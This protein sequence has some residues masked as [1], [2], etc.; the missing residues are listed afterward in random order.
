LGRATY[1]IPTD[2]LDQLS[3]LEARTDEIVPKVLQAG[4]E[5]V[6]ESV[7][8]HLQAVVGVGTKYPARTTG[9]LINA[10]GVSGA[11]LD[12]RG[13][14]TVKVGF[15]EP[16]RSG[17]SNAMLGNIL[18]HGKPGQPPK[19]FLKPAR[20]ASHAACIERMRQVFEQEVEKL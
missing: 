20:I 1:Q 12:R 2:F 10:L 4:G 13:N 18:E 19:P 16:R 9:E 17:N 14:M 11:R 8:D 5:V 15:R 3:R 7:R 6:L